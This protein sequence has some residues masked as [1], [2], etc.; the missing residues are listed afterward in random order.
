MSSVGADIEQR[1]VAR[2]ADWFSSVASGLTLRQRMLMII[3]L[4]ALP[5]IAVA[6]S[7]AAGRIVDQTRQIEL[8]VERLARVG[9]AQHDVVLER[10]R[11]L[12][13]TI[14]A[15]GPAI[16]QEPVSCRQAM[17]QLPQ[18]RSA[19]AGVAVY[20]SQGLRI[21]ATQEIGLPRDASG[22]GWFRKAGEGGGLVLGGY[23]VAGDGTA[24]LTAALPVRKADGG[25]AG[26]VAV[27]I[28]LRWIDFVA[29]TVQLPERMTIS[30]FGAD[31]Q[32]LSHN[33]NSK[34][35]DT[36][37]I[38]APSGP[39]RQQMGGAQEGTLRADDA[40]GSPRVYGFK[41]TGSGGLVIAVGSPRYAEYVEYG[42]ALFHTVAAPLAVLALALLAAAFAAE[43]FV[44]RHVRSLTRT[45][46]AVAAGDL[47]ERSEV[48]YDE[49]E[50]GE[51]AEAFDGMVATIEDEQG[52]LISSVERGE[53]LIR[54]LNH[55]VK[56][57]FQ[58]V[59][60][61]LEIGGRGMSAE[62][63]QKRLK[64]LSGRVLALSEIHRLLYEE[65][66]DRSP[67]LGTFTRELA[68][69]LGT[70]YQ[71]ASDIRISIEPA[72]SGA[73][74]SI[75]HSISLGLILNELISNACKHAFAKG[76][77][78]RVRIS[79]KRENGGE[80]RVILTVADNGKGL[81]DGF[82][83][84]SDGSTGL[85]LIKAL[86]RHIGGEVTVERLKRGTAIHVAF[87]ARVERAPRR[88][89]GNGRKRG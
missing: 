63:A 18:T 19:F 56:N 30:A 76:K 65:Y 62:Q 25:S 21:C 42:D 12:L 64:G 80:R 78:G 17:Q 61:M 36:G 4:A 54:E 37:D 22:L 33:F 40:T 8:T 68:G 73:K 53:V 48:P 39:A 34:E 79:L 47:S 51:L 41:A 31:G 38:A 83:L 7:L 15:R 75:A 14:A 43:M 44:A 60:S 57:N 74:L 27:A 20:D 26:T 72:A 5:G 9:A 50:I 81:P 11:A 32:L 84:S 2:F 46:E 1:R 77:D 10:A 71:D 85:R 70:A 86:T 29:S 87:P 89:K 52:Q 23:E 59:L 66:N 6:F 55:R 88:R 69:L 24:I 82:Q 67:S 28:D 58:M 16:V 35:K 49:H 13:E 45:T 3:L